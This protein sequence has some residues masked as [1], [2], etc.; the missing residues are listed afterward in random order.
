MPNKHSYLKMI[1]NITVRE[2]LRKL[3]NSGSSLTVDI[4]GDVTGN[5]TGD[6]TGD[7]TGNVTGNLTGNVTGD[8]TGDIT[9]VITPNAKIPLE[10]ISS[11]AASASG[12]LMG[13]GTTANP[14]TVAAAG[15]FM[16]FRTESTATSGDARS[17]YLRH[18]LNGVAGNG[19]AI[20]A[21]TKI[22]L[23]AGTARGAH[24][25][26]D[27]TATKGVTGLGAGIDAQVL[28]GDGAMPAGGTYAVVN[29]EW[30]A[31]G[32]STDASAITKGSFLRAVFGGNDTGNDTIEDKVNLLE[33]TGGTAASGNMVGANTAGDATFANWVPIKVDILGTTHYLIAA[34]TIS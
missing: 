4:V 11:G 26:L 19:E 23:D 34:Q 27:L 15:N 17:L 33:V 31:A 24:I 21:F 18:A 25:S 9:G 5:V 2:A 7:I 13:V 20:R 1:P 16:E 12:I 29:M 8:V 30:Y 3:F 6:I 32:A 28:V 10:N 14:A 22:V